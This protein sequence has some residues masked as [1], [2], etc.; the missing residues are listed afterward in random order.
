[1]HVVALSHLTSLS[2]YA[3]GIGDAGAAQVASLSSL[4]SLDL[5]NKDI[6]DAGASYV[7]AL[8]NLTSLDLHGN[9]EQ[10]FNLA[11]LDFD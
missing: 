7:A 11:L 10:F 6:G 4:T 8:L 3:N 5:C 2:V 9:P 1:M